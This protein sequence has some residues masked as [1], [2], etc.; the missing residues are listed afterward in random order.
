M[1][2]SLVCTSFC[3]LGD[4]M[5]EFFYFTGPRII[6]RNINQSVLKEVLD[7]LSSRTKFLS[8]VRL[9][10]QQRQ[11]SFIIKDFHSTAKLINSNHELGRGDSFNYPRVSTFLVITIRKY[12]ILHH[13][14]VPLFSPPSCMQKAR[15][16]RKS[17]DG[18]RRRKRE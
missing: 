5:E 9:L 17:E 14:C 16:G 2:S 13:L 3:R 4:L 10:A 1:T 15:R 7:S 6:V 12:F 18:G 11:K 8:I